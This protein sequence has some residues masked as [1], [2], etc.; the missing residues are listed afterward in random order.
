MHHHQHYLHLEQH[1]YYSSVTNFAA[2][3][4]CRSE[5]TALLTLIVMAEKAR[6]RRSVWPLDLLT[7]WPHIFVAVVRRTRYVLE[8]MYFHHVLYLMCEAGIRQ[9]VLY[10]PSTMVSRC[11]AFVLPP[12]G[13]HYYRIIK[14]LLIATL[15]HYL[16]IASLRPAGSEVVK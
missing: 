16:H 7:S 4:I 10:I 2:V 8:W 11:W 3:L 1:E 14:V 15:V 5:Y 6:R 9:N 13:R 12:A